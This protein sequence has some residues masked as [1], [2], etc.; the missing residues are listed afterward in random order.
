MQKLR[1]KIM[2]LSNHPLGLVVHR[3]LAQPVLP[4]PLQHSSK[5]AERPLAANPVLGLRILNQPIDRPL[6]VLVLGQ[7]DPFHPRGLHLLVQHLC[8]VCGNRYATGVLEGV[9]D[10]L[11]C[12]IVEHRAGFGIANSVSQIKMFMH[13]KEN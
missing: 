12:S 11:L 10:N 1:I 8:V 13:T 4:A 3:L 6:K 9:L 7:I 5:L 2:S